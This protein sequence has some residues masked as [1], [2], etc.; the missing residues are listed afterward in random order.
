MVSIKV[1]L[2]ASLITGLTCVKTHQTYTQRSVSFSAK[3][4][5][6]GSPTCLIQPANK[7]RSILKE[8]STSRYRLFV[9]KNIRKIGLNGLTRRIKVSLHTTLWKARQALE[10]SCKA[11]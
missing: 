1:Y 4:D 11:L 8:T 9:E 5:Q 10:V 6:P 2:V 3:E 7:R